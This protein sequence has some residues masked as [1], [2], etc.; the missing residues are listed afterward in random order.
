LQ[1]LGIEVTFFDTFRRYEKKIPQGVRYSMIYYRLWKINPFLLLTEG[2]TLL[3]KSV[4]FA[5]KFLP[6]FTYK[7][8]TK[9]FVIIVD[10]FILFRHNKQTIIHSHHAYPRSLAAIIIGKHYKI[11]C[12]LTIHASELVNKKLTKVA[13]FVIQNADSVISVSAHT[14][15]LA[16][17]RKISKYI[18]IIPNGVSLKKTSR[19]DTQ[20]RSKYSLNGKDIILF[21]GALV[22][23]KGPH[24][25]IKAIPF[26]ERDN[27]KIVF[28][29]PDIGF[30][31]TLEQI[32]RDKGLEKKTLII[33]EVSG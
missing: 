27:V 7:E 16:Q 33:G 1:R 2:S 23:R 9:F 15:K 24:I 4:F 22:A 32:I 14:K 6:C 19:D 17:S 18:H 21:V 13:K 12:V 10:L 26:I 31:P 28:I 20:I 30:R 25:L 8:L 3:V 29:G 11:P 5:I